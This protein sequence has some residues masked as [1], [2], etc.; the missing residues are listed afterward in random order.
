[1]DQGGADGDGHEDAEEP[2]LHVDGSV[3]E[4]VE[5]EGVEQA[6]EDV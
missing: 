4:F 3:A 1:L 2:V 5:G 6:R